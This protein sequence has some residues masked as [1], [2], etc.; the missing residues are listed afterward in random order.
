MSVY[1]ETEARLMAAV[2]A[3]GQRLTSKDIEQLSE[4]EL[5]IMFYGSAGIADR[6]RRLRAQLKEEKIHRSNDYVKMVKEARKCFTDDDC[7]ILQFLA[8]YDE[9]A[10]YARGIAEHTELDIK[11]VTASLKKLKRR[12]LVEVQSGLFDDDGF[13]AGSGYAIVDRHRGVVESILEVFEN[14]QEALL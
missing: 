4:Q 2:S 5:N 3:T 9:S 10:W 1:D 6:V 7:K 12:G 14:E 8:P 11:A 13:T